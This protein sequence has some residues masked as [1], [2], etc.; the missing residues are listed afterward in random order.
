MA[1]IWSLMPA[2]PQN[3]LHDESENSEWICHPYS[4][5]LHARFG[6]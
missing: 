6:I 4:I 5:N 3:I 2:S 1:D